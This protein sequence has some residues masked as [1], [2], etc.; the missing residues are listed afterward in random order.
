MAKRIRIGLAFADQLTREGRRLLLSSQ[1]DFDVVYESDSGLELLESLASVAMD[2]LLI[3]NRVRS[4]PGSEAIAKYTRRNLKSEEALSAFVLTGPFDS[5]QFKLEG[6]R[7]GATSVVSEEASVE[8][9]LFVLRESVQTETSFDLNNLCRFFASQ[10]I[11]HAG[12]QRWLLRLG[13][14]DEAE[15]KVLGAIRE[16][17]D[18]PDLKA[19]TNLPQTKIRWTL[20]SLQ[21]R[22]GLATRSQLALALYEAGLTPPMR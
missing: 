20:D 2:V 19:V 11:A 22:L 13:N 17:V 15:E 8:E 3:D 12:N 1:P 14:L 6:I 9:L 10:G 21:L 4:L 18:G 16:G 7:C 5:D